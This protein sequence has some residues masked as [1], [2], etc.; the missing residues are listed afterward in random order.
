MTGGRV[1]AKGETAVTE[2]MTSKERVLK[3]FAGEETDRPACFSGM[4][5][6]TT[7]GLN[8]LGYK[9]AQVHLDAKQMAETAIAAWRK[10][11]EELG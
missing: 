2:T 11:H 3:L 8:S 6:V 1:P 4:G 10:A 7:E 5:N 9:F